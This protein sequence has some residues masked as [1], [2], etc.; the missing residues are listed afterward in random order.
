MRTPGIPV[1][2]DVR[3]DSLATRTRLHGA[4]F[5][6]YKDVDGGWPDRGSLVDLG[7][8]RVSILA[9]LF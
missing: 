8:E 7:T 3:L 2:M 1:L 4:I 6:Y 9:A 5:A